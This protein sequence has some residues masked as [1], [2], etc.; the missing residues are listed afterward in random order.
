MLI[1]TPR[2]LLGNNVLDL[3]GLHKKLL[4]K[5]SLKNGVSLDNLLPVRL[6]GGKLEKDSSMVQTGLCCE[7]M[8]TIAMKRW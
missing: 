5:L 8:T 2:V 4:D 6:A 3:R 7:K 1:L